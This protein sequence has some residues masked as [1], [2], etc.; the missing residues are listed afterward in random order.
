M[1]ETD[2]KRAA[3]EKFVREGLG[4]TCPDE[5]FHS[6]R[7][8]QNPATFSDLHKGY[9]LAIGGKL[10]VYLVETNDWASVAANLEQ[11]IRLG[12]EKRDAGE[13]NRFRLVVSTPDIHSARPILM[14]KFDALNELDE[15]LHLHVIAP[16]QL[17]ELRSE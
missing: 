12:R 14:R 9:L 7:V 13:F 6:L 8:E 16:D 1:S 3:I 15:K 4:C 11:I 10:L 2:V 17:P 5:V